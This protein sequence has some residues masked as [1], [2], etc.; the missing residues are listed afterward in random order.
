M[1]IEQWPFLAWL[2]RIGGRAQIIAA[3]SLVVLVTQA[4]L[5]AYG[6]NRGF[7]ILTEV[8]VSGAR[9]SGAVDELATDINTVSDSIVEMMAGVVARADVSQFVLDRPLAIAREWPAVRER[10]SD[11]VDPGSIE[12]AEESIAQMPAF[13]ARLTEAARGGGVRLDRLNEDWVDLRNPLT[14]LVTRARA[15][16]IER[17]EITRLAAETL[18]TRISIAEA[19]ALGAG[20]IVLAATWYLLIFTIARPVTR[21][22]STMTT[23]A[24]GRLDIPIPGRERRDEIGEMA[25]AI[26]VFRGHAVERDA[27]LRERAQAAARLEQLVAERTAELQRRGTMLNATFDN[28]AQGIL[29]VDREL[30][31]LVHNERLVDL[32]NLPREVLANRTTLPEMLRYTAERGDYAPQSPDEVVAERVAALREGRRV[33]SQAKLR[34][35][36]V[37]EVDGVPLLDGG[38]VFT[39][40]DVTEQHR[41]ADEILAARDAAQAANSAKS[42][43]VATMT[44]ELR[45]PM[46]GVLGILELLHQTELNEEQRELINVIGGSAEAL[47]K[48]IDDILDLSK[49][50]A[51]KMDIERVPLTPLPLIEGVAD[52]LA[53][54]A[55]RKKLSFITYVDADVPTAVIGD[56]V[57]L[58]QILF[59]LIGNAIKF[60]ETGSVSVQLSVEDGKSLLL[61]VTDTG[62]GLDEA[63]C[64]RLFQPFV[65]ADS[66]TTRRFG[67]TGLGLSICRQLVHL[68]GGSLGVNSELGRGSTFWVKLPCEAAEAP[69]PPALDDIRGL[70]VLVVEDD[71]TMRRVITSYLS[72]AEADVEAVSTAEAALDWLARHAADIVVVDLKLPGRDGFELQ[73]AMADDPR[74]ADTRTVLLTA[75]NDPADRR[76]ALAAGFSAYLSKPVRKSALLH[77]IAVAVG[78]G[79]TRPVDGHAS[80]HPAS[81]RAISTQRILVAE[82]H[83]TN[84][85]VIRRQLA[86]LGYTAEIVPDGRAALRAIEAA[87]YDLVLTDCHMPELDGYEL[88]RAVRE[89]ERALGQPRVPIIALT[90]ATLKGEAERCFAAGM[91]D[92]LTKPVKLAHLDETLSRWL[93]GHEE[94]AVPAA[95]ARAEES[96]PP[97]QHPAFDL[98]ELREILGTFDDQTRT[99][100]L[101]FIDATPLLIEQI[102]LAVASRNREE[103]QQA[104]HAAK[105]TARSVM[106]TELAEL[107]ASVERHVTDKEWSAAESQVAEANAALERA[108]DFVATL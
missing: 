88:A 85:N 3:A 55:H 81:T 58:R 82:D 61:A 78:R 26:E 27:L 102:R 47:L 13:A 30:R 11:F 34:S 65:Q 4:A 79:S 84:R 19:L 77:T 80:A 72:V 69:A 98:G 62:I 18:R 104:S 96:S 97:G 57:R 39:Y 17:G 53:P 70:R 89:R 12:R 100:M 87:P 16:V 36:L 46:N 86:S 108:R 31:I 20:L 22:A 50:E 67:G 105:G 2:R 64:R 73:H 5:L 49:I 51:G 42:S 92:Y 66:T 107:F 103:A 45:T 101:Q 94:G 90:A 54:H 29:L 24:K 74:L 21:I 6:L 68:M 32:W 40:T 60:T 91:D 28:M 71:P 7:D 41:A 83:E 43:F 56:P 59:N 63:A 8:L 14:R 48:I 37:L 25:L 33:H 75:Y 38:Y 95:I 10:V 99:F 52:T 15:R 1:R 9:A 93:N 76:R 35:G 106:A 23:L 44:H